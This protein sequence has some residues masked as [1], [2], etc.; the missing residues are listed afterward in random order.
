MLTTNDLFERELKKLLVAEIE[1]LQALISGP[2]ISDY[3]QYRYYV[4]A[5]QGLLAAIERCDETRS[6][7][8]QTR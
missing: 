3:A 7:V 8:D 2:N 1:R 5:I 6:I 4:G